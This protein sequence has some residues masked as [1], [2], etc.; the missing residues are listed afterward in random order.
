MDNLATGMPSTLVSPVLQV[1]H[2]QAQEAAKKLQKQLNFIPRPRD[3]FSAVS[4]GIDVKKTDERTLHD[5]AQERRVIEGA[6]DNDRVLNLRREVQSLKLQQL[7][8]NVRVQASDHA[9]ALAREACDD[10]WRGTQSVGEMEGEL[11]G[12]T[13]ELD[14]LLLRLD[15]DGEERTAEDDV[16]VGTGDERAPAADMH[17][18]CA[19]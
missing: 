6:S 18:D 14:S 2:L 9:V 19:G 7:V 10:I 5:L 13:D 16:A 3:E 17:I 12:F 15:L 1:H 11:V 4:T 8:E